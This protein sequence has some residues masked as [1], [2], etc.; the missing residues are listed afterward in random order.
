MPPISLFEL[1]RASLFIQMLR[2]QLGIGF[3]PMRA[4]KHYLQKGELV[5]L[6]FES[7]ETAPWEENY[8][9]YNRKRENRTRPIVEEIQR[10]V[11]AAEL[12]LR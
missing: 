4:A 3:L 8:I 1:E 9:M 12:D 7:S 11:K 5:L 10:Y 2:N 6:D